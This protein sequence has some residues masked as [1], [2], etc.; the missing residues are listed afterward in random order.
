MAPAAASARQDAVAALVRALGYEGTRPSAFLYGADTV[1]GVAPGTT[2]WAAITA[3]G[4]WMRVLRAG[5]MAALRRAFR[6]LPPDVVAQE[7]DGFLVTFRGTLPGAGVEPPLPPGELA[8]RVR[9]HPLLAAVAESGDVLE[10]GVDLGSGGL[11]ARGRLI[12]GPSSPTKGLLDRAAPGAGGLLDFLPAGTFLRIETTLPSVFPAA[13][14]ARRLARHVGFQEERDRVV[15]ERFLR[16]AL[17]GADPK[18]GLA[19]GCEAR[20]GELTVVV[21]ARDA[22]SAVS[23]I[24]KK[25]RSDERSSFGPLVLDRREAPKGLVGWDAW[26][27]QA[28]PQIEDLP[29]CLWSAVDRLA[30]ESKGVP[31]AYSAFGGWSVVA[32][33]PRADAL[34]K[35]ARSR[36]EGGAARSPGA[37]ELRRLRD[38]GEGDYVLG[39]V[40][41]AGAAELPAAD[42]AALRALF[43]DAEGARGPRAVAV[44]GFRASGGLDLRVRVLY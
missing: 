5:D 4:G 19:I 7:T 36:L 6:D 25:L 15:V 10:A 17:T 24:L 40:V 8:L 27:A 30:D 42:L 35:A 32:A 34:A 13:A 38:S 23:P 9:H 12:P 33:G 44:A 29:E 41:E 21:V 14:V 26:V 3:S 16:E 37:E 1:E 20:G 22:D 28:Q 31:V 18:T 2:P 39:V 11:D 43:G